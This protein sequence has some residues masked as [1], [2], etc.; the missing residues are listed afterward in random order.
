MAKTSDN[1][2]LRFE[3]QLLARCG[4]LHRRPLHGDGNHL[5]NDPI[6]S[7]PA[8]RVVNTSQIEIERRMRNDTDRGIKNTLGTRQ[9]NHGIFDRIRICSHRCKV[10][11][12]YG[13]MGSKHFPCIGPSQSHMKFEI[14]EHAAQVRVMQPDN[15][16]ILL[17][18]RKHMYMK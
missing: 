12:C 6:G 2:V 4:L 1:Y 5:R 14:S 3:S 7:L 16:W 11:A 9:L 15:P 18:Q 13:T 10:S 17:Q 8:L